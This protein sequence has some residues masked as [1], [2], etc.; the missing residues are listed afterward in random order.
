MGNSLP[1][2][3]ITNSITELSETTDLNEN[4]LLTQF[5]SLIQLLE[6]N[7]LPFDDIQ[8]VFNNLVT[9]SN[10]CEQNLINFAYNILKFQN[11]DKNNQIFSKTIKHTL[12]YLNIICN[13]IKFLHEERFDSFFFQY[14]KKCRKYKSNNNIQYKSNH[15]LSFIL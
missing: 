13:T 14:L 15:Y 3:K 9:K 12:F 2:D 7:E 4:F 10:F 6:R 8:N 5:Q 1:I 11:I